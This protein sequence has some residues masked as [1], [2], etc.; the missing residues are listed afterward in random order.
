MAKNRSLDDDERDVLARLEAWHDKIDELMK[1]FDEHY[2]I[3]EPRLV[4]AQ[5]AYR[6]IN[7]IL[8]AEFKRTST[9]RGEADS[10]DAERRWYNPT[11][12]EAY[13]HLKETPVNA[14]GGPE[15]F[16]SLNNARAD[17]SHTI[18]SMKLFDSEE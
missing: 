14:T 10:T 17:L 9:D 1:M 15:W 2:V 7:E 5:A 3:P 8:H 4:E 16:S 18:H 6:E 13:V 12:H 11:V